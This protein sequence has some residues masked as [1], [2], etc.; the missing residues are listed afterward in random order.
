M[1]RPWDEGP[2][3]NDSRPWHPSHHQ[4]PVPFQVQQRPHSSMAPPSPTLPPH[5][6]QNR[7]V[8]NHFVEP[9]PPTNGQVPPPR[10]FAQALSG[11]GRGASYLH[12]IPHP[13]GTHQP[14]STNPGHGG[15]FRSAIPSLMSLRLGRGMY[16]D[17][18]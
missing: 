4:S 10:T 3:G 11:G 18:A 12:N 7:P 13:Q 6:A 2:T 14:H 9:L 1:S 5:R 8:P 16:V 17:G 15:N